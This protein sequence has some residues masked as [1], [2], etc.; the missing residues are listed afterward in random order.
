MLAVIIHTFQAESKRQV[1]TIKLTGFSDSDWA[2]SVED[3]KSTAGYIFH[4]GNAAFSWYSGKQDVV[5]QSTAEAEYIAA[6]A[7]TN[8]AIW[9]RKLLCDM[10][11]N[12]NEATEVFVDNKSAIAIAKNPVHH[13][14][15]K[16]INVK[17]HAIREAEK[18]GEV[19]IQ[20]CNS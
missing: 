9:L 10:N 2:G 17:Y 3:S 4:L 16:H 11:F 1:D 8:Q 7:A 14:R 19:S 6:A 12:Q 18:E 15:T 20:Q 5:A 13:G